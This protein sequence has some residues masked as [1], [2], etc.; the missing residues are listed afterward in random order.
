M[1]ERYVDAL[2]GPPPEDADPDLVDQAREQARP[3]AE[4]GIKRTLI[5]QRLAE[6]EGLEA[7]KE[8]VQ[9]RLQA[10]AK[11]M[12]R[13][14]GEVRA[15]MAKSGELRDLER[16]ITEEKVFEYLKEQSEIS[17]GGS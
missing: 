3:A 9:E 12:G 11:R 4:W 5:L 7:T 17:I 2:I 15:R 10:L 1:I 8:D 13:Q 6:D 14:V 16:R